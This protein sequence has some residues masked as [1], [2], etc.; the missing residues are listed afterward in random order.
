MHHPL[1]V[2]SATTVASDILLKDQSQFFTPV[3]T[4]PTIPRHDSLRQPSPSD[5]RDRGRSPRPRPP[6]RQ[7]GKRGRSRSEDSDKGDHRRRRRTSSPSSAYPSHEVPQSYGFFASV[8]KPPGDQLTEEWL[9]AKLK[10][11]DDANFV[12]KKSPK[13]SLAAFS[14]YKPHI[15]EFSGEVDSNT[16]FGGV[17]GAGAALFQPMSRF[18]RFCICEGVPISMH[19]SL[20]TKCLTGP[21]QAFLK[22][23]APADVQTWGVRR[24]V[25]LLYKE[26][27]N[28]HSDRMWT[29]LRARL[30]D[31]CS[32]WS[33]FERGLPNRI[34][35]RRVLMEVVDL[36]TS[37]HTQKA[38]QP[39]IVATFMRVLPLPLRQ[40]FLASL[41]PSHQKK[42]DSMN[43][44]KFED[45]VKLFP[46]TVDVNAVC[47]QAEAIR[48]EH[49][50]RNEHPPRTTH[51]YTQEMAEQDRQRNDEVQR[52]S[53]AVA[54]TVGALS[55]IAEHIDE[56]NRAAKA[57][58]PHLLLP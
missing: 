56:A 7:S 32:F 50:Q 27:S 6:H 33:A 39:E 47:V 9:L 2:A 18:I 28:T 14:V 38:E 5:A 41:N 30:S 55:A 13:D 19:Y 49:P 35:L 26:F 10:E 53:S 21:A 57:P 54:S 48:N 44:E 24:V 36:L 51:A 52:L 46:H 42:L 11:D 45:L 29:R 15:P 3:E 22:A 25:A 12:T 20:L 1:N 31:P 8:L 43:A 34:P 37:H 17:N 40:A 23:S 58:M 16:L 4:D